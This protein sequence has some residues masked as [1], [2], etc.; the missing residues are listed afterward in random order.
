M[1][2]RVCGRDISSETFMKTHIL[3]ILSIFIL[4]SCS[5]DDFA[6]G[7]NA[8]GN[9][10]TNKDGQMIDASFDQ[11][12]G[13]LN[14][15]IFDQ[16]LSTAVTNKDSGIIEL[17][18]EEY[19]WKVAKP[20]TTASTYFDCEKARGKINYL[21]TPLD[22]TKTLIKVK[23]SWIGYKCES[24]GGWQI[25]KGSDYAQRQLVDKIKT[26]FNLVEPK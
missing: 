10:S 6:T 9:T 4:S 12:W 19:D 20:F 17:K 15:Y 3:L 23:S 8:V 1:G 7:I 18:E 21:V 11:V 24:D 16:D 25:L 5:F 26:R 13:S 22:E 2:Q 14:E